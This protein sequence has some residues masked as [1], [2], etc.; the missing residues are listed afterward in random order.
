MKLVFLLALAVA[1]TEVSCKKEK[2]KP[3]P[4]PFLTGR[5]WTADTITINPPA[6]YN[7]LNADD[8]QN[9]R[10]ANG[11]FKNAEITFNEDGSVTSGGDYDFGYY[12]WILIN[13]N[14]DIEV[15]VSNGRR[16]T[17]F[18]W[19]ANNLQLTYRKAFSPSY[20][21]TFVYK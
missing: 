5:K 9:Y 11:W 15:L 1:L 3:M 10:T 20:D 17:L 8:Q 19:A 16:D 2:N 21:C 6:V 7:L 14:S 18:N 4:V 13:N 12:Q